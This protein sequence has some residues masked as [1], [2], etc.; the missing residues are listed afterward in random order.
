MQEMWLV[1]PSL[2]FRSVRRPAMLNITCVLIR[3]LSST[4]DI[5][6]LFST[7]VCV[8]ARNVGCIPDCAGRRAVMPV[9]PLYATTIYH[10]IPLCTE[11]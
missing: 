11:Q 6:W 2:V 1:F 8:V 7:S 10:Y 3:L 9:I 4:L 5:S